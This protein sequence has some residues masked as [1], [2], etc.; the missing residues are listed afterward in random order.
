MIA[1]GNRMAIPASLIAEI[2]AAVVRGVHRQT[3]I[4]AKM[5]DLFIAEAAR[6]SARDV[7][8][9][10][11]VLT[12]LA[13][14]IEVSARALLARRLA[15]VPNAPPQVTRALAR[16]EAADVACPVLAESDGLDDEALHYCASTSGPPQL[17]AIAARKRISTIV[18]DVLVKRGDRQVAL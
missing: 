9:F 2:D 1:R 5:S 4:V 13:A 14:K 16:D 8:L 7:A 6:F 15:P 11:E 18:T 17:L 10:D 3:S 12:R